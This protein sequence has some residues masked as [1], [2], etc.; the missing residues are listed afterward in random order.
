MCRHA[1]SASSTDVSK[2]R[3]VLPKNVKPLVYDLTLEPNF[4][5]FK[6]TGTVSIEYA[7]HPCRPSTKSRRLQV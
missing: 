7:Y 3:V 2:G 4:E 6:Y 5:T 1:D